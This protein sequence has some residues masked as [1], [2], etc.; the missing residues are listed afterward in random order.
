MSNIQPKSFVMSIGLKIKEDS[1][2]L[3]MINKKDVTWRG[4]KS[5]S[6]KMDVKN[7]RETF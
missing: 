5:V 2:K 6:V 1:R 3:A 7:L 4:A